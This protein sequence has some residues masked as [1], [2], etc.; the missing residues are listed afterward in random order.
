MGS[1][2]MSNSGFVTIAL[3]IPSRCFIPNEKSFTFYYLYLAAS[4]NVKHGQFHF[5][6]IAHIF[7]M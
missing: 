6:V 7:T 4:L 3:A 1:S 2:K 5:I